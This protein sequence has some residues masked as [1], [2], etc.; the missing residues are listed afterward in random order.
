MRAKVP[1]NMTACAAYLESLI[2]GP[3]VLGEQFSVADAYLYALTQW[4]Q[5][6]WLESVYKTSIRFDGLEHLAGWYGRMRERPAVR[7]ALQ[8]EGLR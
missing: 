1:Q 5:A 6:P 8:A 4:G 3:W 7:Q 2:A